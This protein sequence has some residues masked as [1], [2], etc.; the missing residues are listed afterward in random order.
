MFNRFVSKTVLKAAVASKCSTN[1][2]KLMLMSSYNRQLVQTSKATFFDYENKDKNIFSSDEE[3][4][5]VRESSDSF[6]GDAELQV[7]D[8][9]YTIE[10]IPL[11]ITKL[12]REVGE[13]RRR[14]MFERRSG[15]LMKESYFQK[16]N[17]LTSMFYQNRDQIS[18]EY[19]RF[20][21]VLYEFM[22]YH[23][24]RRQN[25]AFDALEDIVIESNI[26]N[27]PI[28]GIKNFVQAMNASNRGRREIIDS[29]K[30]H[31]V[32]R[33]AFNDVRS[34][35]N[36]TSCLNNL[37]AL[38]DDY[39][40]R[41]LKAIQLDYQHELKNGT[42]DLE[43]GY[44][45]YP[46]SCRQQFNTVIRYLAQTDLEITE[47]DI[48]TFLENHPATEHGERHF[49]TAN[50]HTQTLKDYVLL[51]IYQY[52]LLYNDKIA[53]YGDLVNLMVFHGE[54][55]KYKT[56]LEHIPHLKEMF[57][58]S[59]GEYMKSLENEQVKTNRRSSL[60]HTK[61]SNCL[62]ELGV[63]FN[64][65]E[66]VSDVFK[67]DFY[68]PDSN[69]VL[70]YLN[71]SDYVK[72]ADVKED[73]LKI[74]R[75]QFRE[76]ILTNCGYTVANVDFFDLIEADGKHQVL[77]G[78]IKSKLGLAVEE[79]EPETKAEETTTTTTE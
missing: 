75:C 34:N 30:A 4:A 65:Y 79:A 35:L 46:G 53:R 7:H 10:D 55:S 31:L 14:P 38:D 8:G 56:V 37:R 44:I 61:I 77:V 64:T 50:E 47:D 5:P 72:T 3:D 70:G 24:I 45:M 18:A 63:Y 12:R 29:V 1:A 36:I 22:A 78:I 40:L 20:A 26:E 67:T 9:S 32:E 62:T 74:G 54:G 39:L 2:M 16:F 71:P 41:S 11:Y 49:V 25:S 13:I 52:S 43:K 42:A 23:D 66:R 15:R 19:P 57:E 68:I 51:A 6:F 48:K 21:T 27:M 59:H 73:K 17:N 60:N 58:K 69:T 76:N 28:P 33:N